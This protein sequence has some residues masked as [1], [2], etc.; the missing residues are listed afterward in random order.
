MRKTGSL[1]LACMLVLQAFASIAHADAAAGEIALE[2]T[3]FSIGEADGSVLLTINR[4]G[5]SE[6]EVTIEYATL[7]G[8]AYGGG[9]YASDSGTLI[10][11]EGETTKSISIAVYDDYDT[12][13]DEAF[14]IE[15]SNPTGG[16]A[17]GP[18][19][20]ADITIWDNDNW[21]PDPPGELSLES[22]HFTINEGA[23][24]AVFSVNRTGGSAGQVTID[25]STGS[26][27]AAE[28][29][30]FGGVT[31]TLVFA[32]GDTWETFEVPISDDIKYEGDETFTISLSNPSGEPT[33][34]IG[35][36]NVTIVDNDDP[37][38]PYNPGVFEFESAA[39]SVNENVNEGA[40]W[41]TVKRSGGTDGWVTLDYTFSDGT[42]SS[43]G[44]YEGYEGQLIFAPGESSRTIDAVIYNDNEFEGNEYFT[45]TLSNPTS[46]AELGTL[47]TTEVTIIDDEEYIPEN[48]GEFQFEGD[49]YYVNEGE[50]A[51]YL[52]VERNNGIDGQVTVDY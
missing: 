28:G 23:G 34:G 35:S 39:N 21:I 13:G 4:T 22:D 12:E 50:G 14:T 8:S 25:Y 52:T 6:G 43:G 46:D 48:P 33:T 3:Y 19:S 2:G 27:S 41:V 9:D 37:E 15:L 49:S 45:I 30:D 16:A 36:A 47:T 18:A 1:L 29:E 7:D 32:E 42:A 40:V 26:G 11:A 20:Y 31:G 44:D 51:L 5:G 17:L 38:T 24:Y 10:F